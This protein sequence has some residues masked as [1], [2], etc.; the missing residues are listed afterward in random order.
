MH[1]RS[2]FSAARR[3]S[4]LASCVLLCACGSVGS[5][6]GSDAPVGMML[7][8]SE[9]VPAVEIAALARPGGVDDASVQP[10]ASAVHTALLRCGGE[11]RGPG[12]TSALRQGV[13]LMFSVQQ[14]RLIAAAGTT[15]ASACMAQQLGGARMSGLTASR[16]LVLE[17]R[18]A[19]GA[20]QASLSG[21]KTVAR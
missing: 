4:T 11:G 21:S 7:E 1:P 2:I 5:G 3:R 16:S 17:L 6:S 8:A 18:A 19:R 20:A 9:G 12:L 14:G 10:L 15:D 13:R